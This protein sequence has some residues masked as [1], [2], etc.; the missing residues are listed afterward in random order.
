[1][2]TLKMTTLVPVFALVTTT[3]A[4]ASHLDKAPLPF[5]NDDCSMAPDMDFRSRCEAHDRV[6]YQQGTR[7]QRGQAD[8]ELRLR[9]RTKRHSILDDINYVA[10]PIGGVPW[11]PTSWRWRFGYPYNE[12]H[13]GYTTPGAP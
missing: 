4:M 13:R 9:I 12:G 11:R 1:M 8:R 7:E 5:V 2:R 3:P 10:V 6:Y